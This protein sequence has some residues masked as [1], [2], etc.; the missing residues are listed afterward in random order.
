MRD[1]I[2]VAPPLII[3]ADEI[4]TLLGAVRRGLDRLLTSSEPLR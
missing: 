1:A 2:A 3:A 4:D